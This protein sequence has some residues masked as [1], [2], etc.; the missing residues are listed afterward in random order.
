[1]PIEASAWAL[2]ASALDMFES[3]YWY[4]TNIPPCLQS[5]RKHNSESRV[6]IVYH[7]TTTHY[8]SIRDTSTGRV[9]RSHSTL[10]RRLS[11]RT[12]NCPPTHKQ[13]FD[14]CLVCVWSV[15]CTGP[16]RLSTQNSSSSSTAP[17]YITPEQYCRKQMVV[18]ERSRWFVVHVELT[19][20]NEPIQECKTK[21]V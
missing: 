17:V 16:V 15:Y 18:G 4:I 2:G 10:A 1:M 21:S 3:L 14:I 7:L 19:C 6:R 13:Y 9:P 11:A 20:D 5:S 12:G 8:A